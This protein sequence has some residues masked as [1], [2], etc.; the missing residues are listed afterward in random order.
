VELAFTRVRDAFKAIA[1]IGVA[2]RLPGKVNG[3]AVSL[4]EARIAQ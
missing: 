1:D 4:A 2:E 3:H